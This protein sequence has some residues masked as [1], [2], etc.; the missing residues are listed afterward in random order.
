MRLMKAASFLVL[1]S[2]LAGCG[3]GSK[4]PV[5]TSLGEL[6]RLEKL[7]IVSTDNPDA[8]TLRAGPGETLLLLHFRGK[9]E[10]SFEGSTEP[11][12]ALTDSANREFHP[13]SHG[14]VM[15]DG[16]LSTR[17]WVYNGELKGVEGRLVF[18]GTATTA[19]DHFAF[20][21]RVPQDAKALKLLDGGK[22]LALD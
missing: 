17:G 21:Y 5:Q 20:V 14:T 16:R 18:V 6:H 12:Y 13:I 4:L 15:P 11:P 7:Q 10:I 1:L 8:S 19:Q 2:V 9:K 3:S 22:A